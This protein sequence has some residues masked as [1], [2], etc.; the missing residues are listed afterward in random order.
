MLKLYNSK[1]AARIIEQENG[2]IEALSHRYPLPPACVKAVLYKELRGIDIFDVVADWIVKANWTRY[3]LWQCLRRR[4]WVRSAGPL[5][6]C[7][8]FGKRDSST[9][10]GQIF[11]YVAINAINFSLDRGLASAGSLDIP[12][13]RRLSPD[14]PDDLRTIWYRLHNNA[15][16]NIECVAL[17][18]LAA[19]EEMTGRIDFAHYTEEEMSLVFTRYNASV[20]HITDYG[21][22]AYRCYMSFR[23]SER[24]S[25]ARREH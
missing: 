7:G 9:G 17:N 15:A 8:V 24:R 12:E 3:A 6:R 20:K 22:E 10:Y 18:L 5:L 2:W 21:R 25:P 1:K 19:A 16:F 14:V 4:G 11:G 13:D 23:L